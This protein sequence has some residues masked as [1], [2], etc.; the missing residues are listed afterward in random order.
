MAEANQMIITLKHKM[1]KEV[2]KCDFCPFETIWGFLL[3]YHV[4]KHTRHFFCWNSPLETYNCEFCIFE[5]HLQID[6]MCHL[7]EKHFIEDFKR[8]NYDLGTS[9]YSCLNCKIKSFSAYFMLKHFKDCTK[10]PERKKIM[11][12]TTKSSSKNNIVIRNKKNDLISVK[13]M[14]CKRCIYKMKDNEGVDLPLGQDTIWYKCNKCL[15]KRKSK[16]T[17]TDLIVYKCELCSYQGKTISHLRRHMN[18]N[19]C[20]NKIK[21]HY[22][23]SCPY[24]AKIFAHIKSHMVNNHVSEDQINLYNNV[25]WRRNLVSSQNCD[26]EHRCQYCSYI[27]TSNI[28]LRRHI[29]GLHKHVKKYIKQNYLKQNIMYRCLEPNCLYEARNKSHLK[30]HMNIKHDSFNTGLLCALK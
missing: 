15:G 24:R 13:L 25:S 11:K 30:S 10:K 5:T 9:E 7:Q 22:C 4:K 26:Q 6:L 2:Q 3:K 28:T 23:V 21:W 16:K 27:A 29:T 19:H 14:R 17:K 8:F 1:I 18:Y 20:P 12:K